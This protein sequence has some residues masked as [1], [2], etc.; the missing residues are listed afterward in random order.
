M[1]AWRPN[2]RGAPMCVGIHCDYST[3]NNNHA[4]PNTSTYRVHGVK[5]VEH[6]FIVVQWVVELRRQTAAFERGNVVDACSVVF[7]F[8]AAQVDVA[9]A[10]PNVCVPAPDTPDGGLWRGYITTVVH[11]NQG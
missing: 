10:I 8:I 2:V 6:L 1:L 7:V 4:P 5:Q 3:P 9:L 11:V